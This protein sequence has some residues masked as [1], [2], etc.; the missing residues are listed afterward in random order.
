MLYLALPPTPPPIFATL[1]PQ[2]VKS[3]AMFAKT[4]PNS[5]RFKASTRNDGTVSVA[6][7]QTSSACQS[8]NI[9]EQSDLVVNLLSKILKNSSRI[10]T[11]SSRTV[12]SNCNPVRHAPD[13]N[14]SADSIPTTDKQLDTKGFSPILSQKKLINSIKNKTSSVEI[15]TNYLE[16]KNV[17]VKTTEQ[18]S[19]LEEANSAKQHKQQKAVDKNPIG[20]ILETV[21]ELISVSLYASINSNIENSIQKSA[22]TNTVENQEPQKIATTN[23]SVSDH[24]QDNTNTQ[25]ASNSSGHNSTQ[26]ILALV[27]ELISASLYASLNNTIRTENQAGKIELTPPNSNFSKVA[28]NNQSTL[29]NQQLDKKENLVTALKNSASQNNPSSSSS[30]SNIIPKPALEL[31]QI[32]DTPFLVGVLINGR[33]AGT[34]DVLIQD[35]TLFIPLESF[36]Q[37]TGFT[38]EE[39]NRALSA[40]TPLGTVNL[41]SDDLRQINGVIYITKLALQQ[42]LKVD[43]ELNTADI[44]LLVELP[45]RGGGQSRSA[46]QLKPDALPPNTAFSTLQQDLNIITSSSRTDIR[47]STLL[48]GRLAGGSWRARLENDFENTPNLSEYF[49]YKRDGQFRYQIGRQFLGLNPLLDGL[50][51]TGLQFGYTNLPADSFNTTYSA[52]ELLPKRSRPV[53]TFRGTAPAAS[54][55]QLRVGSSIVAQQQ[56]GFNGQYEFLDVNLPVGQSSDV[57]ILIFDRNNL[58]APREIR[59][60]RINASDLL[61]PAGG[62]VQLAGLGFTG[63]LAQTSLLGDSRFKLENEGQLAGFY[64]IRQGL[65]NNLTFEGGIQALPNTFQAQAGLVWRLANPAILS[66]SVGSSNDKLGYSADLDIQLDRLQI[67]ANSQS[68]PQRYFSNFKNSREY[69]NH[70]LEV[71]YNFGNRLDLGFIAR[72]RQSETESANYILPTFSARPFSSLFLSGRPDFEGRYLFN[73]FYQPNWAT[74]LSFNTYG[75]TYISD[76]SYKF[77]NNY[78]MS[79]GGEFGGNDAARYTARFGYS[80]NDFR[81]FSWNVGLGVTADGQVGP[82]AGASMQVLPGLLGRIEYQGIPSR[83][84]SY[85]GGFGDDRLSISLI[86]DLSFGGGRVAPAWSG[87]VSKERGAISGQLTVGRAAKNF[88]LSG[89]NIRVY[90]NRNQLMGTARTDS[91]GNF[92]VGNLPEGT[93]IVELEPDELPVELSVPKTSLI[94]QVANS[95]VTRLDFPVR[96]EYGL[97]GK[98]TD[99]AGQP[100]SQVRVELTNLQGAR[101]ISAVTDR[102]GLYRLDGVPVGKYT[103]RVSLQDELNRNDSLPKRQVEIRDEFVYNQNLQLPIS[104]AAKKR[105]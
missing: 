22:E 57:E 49:Y 30:S 93:Y 74:R 86:S 97:A 68:L 59:T 82:V 54:L 46:A 63:N 5:A 98:V 31:A 81:A 69:F 65:T 71:K 91:Q 11:S 66:A 33:E 77:N 36:A 42:K 55:V 100:I 80:P 79:L 95:A 62:N 76:F 9:S 3:E 48:G 105:S 23:N 84:L 44:N 7:A 75:D 15:S 102:F 101:V 45:W 85:L 19:E 34:I 13:S 90:N 41:Q 25:V 88:D 4:S 28:S 96:V 58:R 40:K 56:V 39:N 26:K 92:M 17:N 27:Q 10:K 72:N 64:Q 83:S 89:S 73:A 99:V 12:I 35:N 53:Q 2:E 14:T 16:D 47:S 38:I 103:L 6:T 43:V 52:N 18:Q 87:G 104:A 61:L 29:T 94:A 67:N 70:S 32:P 24:N 51:L 50:S 20:Q 78:Q 21:Q 37:V 8:S 1:A 60:V